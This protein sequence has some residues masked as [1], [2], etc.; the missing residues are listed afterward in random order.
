[1]R[2]WETLIYEPF[3]EVLGR[4]ANFFTLDDEQQAKLS[5]GMEVI[6]FN[7]RCCVAFFGNVW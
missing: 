2:C 1:V 4:A 5:K 6:A 3:R 7:V